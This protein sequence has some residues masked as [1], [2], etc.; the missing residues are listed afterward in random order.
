[1]ENRANY[2]ATHLR[3]GSKMGRIGELRILARDESGEFEDRELMSRE[4]IIELIAEGEPVFVWDYEAGGLGDEIV[5]I[6][7]QGDT[8]LRVDGQRLCADNLGE[9]PEI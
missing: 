7:V 9:L 4:Q 6:R 1:M 8:Y 3:A 2:I 5:L